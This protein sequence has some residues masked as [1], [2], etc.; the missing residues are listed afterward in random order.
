VHAVF[1]E[2]EARVADCYQ[3][4]RTKN[5]VMV[6]YFISEGMHSREDIPRMLGEA[7]ANIQ[8]RLKYNQPTWRNPT[9]RR[10]KRLWY[11]ASVGTAPRVSDV[12]LERVREMVKW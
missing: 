2:E 8:D 5:I 12:I 10:G 7:S 1:L 9:E 3:L 4:A 11:S 6:P